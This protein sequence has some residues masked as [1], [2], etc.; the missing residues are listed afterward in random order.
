VF[1]RVGG[2]SQEGELAIAAAMDVMAGRTED[3]KRNLAALEDR[4]KALPTAPEE[5]PARGRPQPLVERVHDALT[6]TLPGHDRFWARWV[7][8]WDQ[9]DRGQVR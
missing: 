6:R 7:K 2:R 3:A 9:Q 8:T 4:W 1:G 5:R